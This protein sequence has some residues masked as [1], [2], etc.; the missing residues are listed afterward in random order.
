MKNFKVTLELTG[1]KYEVKAESID[2]AL[3]KIGLKWNQIKGKGVLKIVGKDSYFE[4]MFFVKQLRQ[5]F[6]NKLTRQLW[7]KRM[8]FLMKK[9]IFNQL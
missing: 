2:L 8:E 1:N 5:M 3:E 7:A 6:S 4:R 9:N